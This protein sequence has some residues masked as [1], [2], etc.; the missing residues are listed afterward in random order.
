MSSFILSTYFMF[1]AIVEHYCSA[2]FSNGVAI[3]V[4]ADSV[5][6]AWD[7]DSPAS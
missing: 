7:V 1:I 3:P 4:A 6:A 2:T 5:S